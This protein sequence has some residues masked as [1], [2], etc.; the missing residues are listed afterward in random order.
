MSEP[1][2]AEVLSNVA[3][4]YASCRSYR[5]EGEVTTRIVRHALVGS[6]T[7]RQPFRTAF[8]RPDRFRFEFRQM[9]VGPEDE[10]P[11]Y[12]TWSNEG[13]TR[14]WW[15]YQPQVRVLDSIKSGIAA[16]TGVSHGSGHT[17][18]SLLLR[19]LEL[20]SPLPAAERV[21]TFQREPWDERDCIRLDFFSRPNQTSSM[22]LD[23]NSL[24]VLRIVQQTDVTAAN[25]EESRLRII[26][27]VEANPAAF[28][29]QAQSMLEHAR[30]G[31]SQPFQTL[32][33]TVYRPELDVDLTPDLFEFTPP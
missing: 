24:L 11:L 5:D 29:E 3:N 9:T 8:V 28:G 14:S 26:R 25:I 16:A 10:W 15:T 17:I 7:T 30:Q 21:S 19:D 4:V 12:V 23:A 1:S 31:G 20:R 18:P 27:E 13:R 2:I 33:E 6:H 22:W 32:S